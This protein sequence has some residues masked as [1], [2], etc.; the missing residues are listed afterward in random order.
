MGRMIVEHTKFSF[1]LYNF[2]GLCMPCDFQSW[3]SNYMYYV[4]MIFTDLFVAINLITIGVKLVSPN[5]LLAERCL[6]AFTSISTTHAILKTLYCYIQRKKFSTLLKMWDNSFK[7]DYYNK[8]LMKL[9]ETDKKKVKKLICCLSILMIAPMIPWGG[10]PLF[11]EG[12]SYFIPQL[13]QE[14]FISVPSWHPY[15]HLKSPGF[16][17][18]GILQALGALWVNAK[19]V[20]FDC[21][22]YGLLSRQIVQYRHLKNNLNKIISNIQVCYDGHVKLMCTEEMKFKIFF[23]EDRVRRFLKKELCLW[24]RHHQE[25]I[26]YA[27]YFRVIKKQIFK[28]ALTII[29]YQ[30]G[31]RISSNTF[32][33]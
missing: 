20:A 30:F 14:R 31:L 11:V 12:F 4:Y 13:R 9:L 23:K 6:C 25:L 21:L 22:L 19:V 1:Y 26:R 16:E 33:H 3:N 28:Y 2:A 7:N 17:I 29:H 24:I 8:D 32:V 18:T 27:T 5:V 15:D 10:L